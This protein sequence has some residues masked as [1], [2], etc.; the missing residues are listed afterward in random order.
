MAD[1]VRVVDVQPII[2]VLRLLRLLVFIL[3]GT[4]VSMVVN[5]VINASDGSF[6]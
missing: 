4:D 6:Q 2:G 1:V 5:P 3:A